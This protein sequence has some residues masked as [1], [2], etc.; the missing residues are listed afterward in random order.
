MS[1]LQSVLLAA[2]GWLAACLAP[3]AC[4]RPGRHLVGA[5]WG[6]QGGQEEFRT[7]VHI[8]QY[9]RWVLGRAVGGH[10]A[11]LAWV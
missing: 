10:H 11:H 5:G 4:P 7:M 8:M 1:P 3:L 2:A 6:C 9:P